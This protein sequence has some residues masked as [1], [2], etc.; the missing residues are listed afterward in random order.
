MPFV[1]VQP[2]DQEAVAAAVDILEASRRVDDPTAPE[3]LP[4][5]YR[6]WLRYGWDLKP[7]EQYLY[8]PTSGAEPVGVLSLE[9]PVRDNQHLVWAEITTRPDRRRQGHGSTMMAEVLRRT[10]EAGRTTV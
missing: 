6:G 8:L 9:L 10:R 7:A 1:R 3:V 5:L 4:D 2:D